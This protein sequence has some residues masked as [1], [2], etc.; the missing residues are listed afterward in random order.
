MRKI[1]LLLAALVALALPA[2]AG[3]VTYN[4]HYSPFGSQTANVDAQVQWQ[5]N[6][7][8]GHHWWINPITI[9]T[10]ASGGIPIWWYSNVNNAPCGHSDYGCHSTGG[11]IWARVCA[12]TCE[13][14]VLSHEVVEATVDP[15]A[16]GDEIVDPVQLN[17]YQIS[18]VWVEDF[19]FPTYYS[20]GC[21]TDDWMQIMHDARA[22]P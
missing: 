9:N 21:G 5:V 1:V 7:Q 8:V 15:A 13:T 22:C 4:V 14:Q 12:F 3:A 2:A 19:V 11:Q 10:D 6:Q 17:H 18:G 16:T 20:G